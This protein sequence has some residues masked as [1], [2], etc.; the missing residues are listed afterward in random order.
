MHADLL[1]GQQEDQILTITRESALRTRQ[2]RPRPCTPEAV[3]PVGQR[4]ASIARNGEDIVKAA[5][6]STKRPPSHPSHSRHSVKH[7]QRPRARH[8]TLHSGAHADVDTGLT[9]ILRSSNLLE[10]VNMLFFR[11]VTSP[12]SA[13]KCLPIGELSPQ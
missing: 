3:G 7:A 1:L 10:A 4:F 11:F 5:S 6:T 2:V 12:P 8:H 13:N 9:A